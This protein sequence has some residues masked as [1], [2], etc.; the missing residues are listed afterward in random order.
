MYTVFS[1]RQITN[2]YTVKIQCRKK[3]GFKTP[4]I[5]NGYLIGEMLKNVE[6][7]YKMNFKNEEIIYFK[8]C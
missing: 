6:G 2:F 3:S 7:P 5:F 8:T 1:V 4:Y